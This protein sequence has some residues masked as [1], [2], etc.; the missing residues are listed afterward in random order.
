MMKSF[1][2][3]L[4]ALSTTVGLAIAVVT[5]VQAIEI[6]KIVS[7]GGIEAWFVPDKSVPLIAVSF[8]FR[9]AGS[10]TDPEAR[11][12]LAGM[13]TGLLDEGAG[14]LV[15]QD[16]Q[17]E[18][19][20]IAAQLSFDTG[21]DNFSGRLRTLTSERDRAFELL[22]LALNKPRFDEKP[23]NR[24][25]GQIL[26]GLKQKIENPRH[27]AG[28]LWR[29][30][31]FPNHPYAKPSDGT[32]KSINAITPSDLSQFV[33]DRFGRDRLI[34]GVVGDI[35]AAELKTRLDQVFGALP[36]K[37]RKFDIADTQPA[38][39][40]KVLIVK[41]PIPQSI[42]VLGHG[43]IKRTDPDWYA[44]TLVNRVFGGGGLSSRLYEEV[45]EKRGLAYSVYSYLNPL[46]HASLLAGGT[47]TQN[48]RAGESLDVIREQ[49]GLLGEKGITAA[50]LKDVKAYANGSF[51]LRL[52]SSR[53]IANILV[54]MQL[55]DLGVDYLAK[56]TELINSVTLEQANNVARRLYK[57][58][59]LTVVV[60]GDPA[61]IEAKP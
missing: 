58:D 59:D 16:F 31:V 44:A 35:S 7:D 51:P 41:K 28:E 30:T 40:G 53:G 54:G 34:V 19:E 43:G 13:V 11:E 48:P 6:Q 9:G 33:K 47:A 23:V 4:I 15:S 55:S 52:G 12:G 39:A 61:G 32:V 1:K 29:N 42:I 8:A 37:S 49:W 20:E 22:R 45:R 18:L 25:R 26:A 24:I 38:G 27:I 14:D 50:E 21:R 60:V 5:P 3:S 10:A 36:A 17:R 46:D 56:R 57:T 2:R